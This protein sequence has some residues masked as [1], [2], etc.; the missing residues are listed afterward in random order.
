MKLIIP[1]AGMGTRMRPHT[2]VTPKPLLNIAGKSIVR[3]LAEDIT[4]L[5][6]SKIDE[7]AFII[8]NFGNKVEKEL[9]DIAERL[10][11]VGKI[12]Y[13][14]QALGTAHAIYC[15]KESLSGKVV[16]AF[17]DTLFD[18][19]FT[20]DENAESVIWV[21]KVD[22][23]EQF[24]VVKLDENGYITE[25]IEK[26]KTHVSDLAIIGIYY[27]RDGENFKNE[28]KYLIDNNIVVNGEFQLTDAL[29]NMKNN[30]IK[31][32]SQTV[33]Q[34]LDCGNK[35]ATILTNKKV[36]DKSGSI[37]AN[38]LQIS[39]SVIIDPV[40]I[41]SNVIISNSVIGPHVSVEDNTHI[42]NSV[43]ENSII[44]TNSIVR[45]FNLVN[46]IIGNHVQISKQ[47]NQINIGDYT[48][49]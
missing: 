42:E 8:G 33:T 32:E 29:E 9:I 16:V 27:F 1:M 2:L 6:K 7:I 43:I 17:A 4:N 21:K 35:N 5:S 24:G 31:F 36:L 28:L 46:S 30:N 34:W 25:F 13:Q 47:S 11:A 20:L 23:P 12:Y 45:N 19:D 18:A 38:D 49:I 40:F 14:E 15:A 22:N 3:R 48:Q 26:P 10:G 41:G 37:I 44:Y 39:N